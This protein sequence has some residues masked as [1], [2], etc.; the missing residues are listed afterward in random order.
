MPR[1]KS[2]PDPITTPPATP[3]ARV[4]QVRVYEMTKMHLTDA[5]AEAIATE[6]LK[7]VKQPD[8]RAMEQALANAKKSAAQYKER[9]RAA[10]SGF[11]ARFN[12]IEAEMPEE[13]AAPIDRVLTTLAPKKAKDED[14]EERDEDFDL[15]VPDDGD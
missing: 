1:P 10:F 15:D 4:I 3:A 14:V 7:N 13:I 2:K 8:L 5:Q 11:H 9:M 6:V 12:A